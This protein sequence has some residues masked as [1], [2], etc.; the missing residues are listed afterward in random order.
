MPRVIH[1]AQALVDVVV[2]VASLPRRGGNAVATSYG[3]YAGGAVNTLIAAVRSGAVA[4]HAGAHGTG[5]NGDLI[6]EALAAEGISLCSPQVPALDTGMCF[7]MIEPTAE[8]TF[9]TTQGAE[10]HITVE[11]LQTSRPTEGDVVC[12]SGYSLLGQTR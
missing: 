4:V 12:V 10:R 9:V 2:D 8:R 11:S 3:R 7:V 6:R 5:P 1:T